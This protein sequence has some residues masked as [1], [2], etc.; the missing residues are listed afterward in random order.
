MSS[1]PSVGA[2]TSLNVPHFLS[3]GSPAGLRRQMLKNNALNGTA[4]SYF[5][6]QFVGGKW[7]AW[8]YR[9][10]EEAD[11]KAQSV[12]SGKTIQIERPTE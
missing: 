8:F 7:Y 5:D 9:T 6:I 1:N 12:F 10:A 3:A 11:L 4:Y 2:S